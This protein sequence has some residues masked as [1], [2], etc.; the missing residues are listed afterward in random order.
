MFKQDFK[1]FDVLIFSDK[2]FSNNGTIDCY[3]VSFVLWSDFSWYF[4]NVKNLW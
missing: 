2:S 3:A 4:M 1:I